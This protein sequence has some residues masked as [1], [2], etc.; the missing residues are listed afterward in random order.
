MKKI[1]AQGNVLTFDEEEHTYKHD[2]DTIPGVTSITGIIDK[3]QPIK[4]WALNE[5]RDYINEKFEDHIDE[6]NPFDEVAIQ[7]LADEARTAHMKSS[8]KGINVGNLL[9]EYA[10]DYILHDLDLED[11]DEPDFPNNEAAQESAIEFLDWYENNEVEPV[12]TEQMIFHPE[13]KYA[14]TYDLKAWVNGNLL[15]IDFKTSSGI[16]EEHLAQTTAYMFGEEFRTEE[17]LDGIGVARFPKDG[18]GFESEIVTERDEI[19]AHFEGF[20]GCRKVFEWEN[21]D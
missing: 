11:K 6:D 14:G 10:E 13:H 21:R 4:W 20:K 19:N 7:E 8:N 5:A 1:N 18:A 15:I 9:H 2:G 12:Q 3:S 17:K 16:Y